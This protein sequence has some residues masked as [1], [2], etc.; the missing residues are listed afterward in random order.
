MKESQSVRSANAEQVLNL[1]K[2]LSKLDKVLHR[3]E[4]DYNKKI[5]ILKQELDMK[6]VTSKVLITFNFCR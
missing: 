6:E 3:N 2:C 1:K 5:E 4:K